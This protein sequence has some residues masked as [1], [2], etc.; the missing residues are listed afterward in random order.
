MRV[1][2]V[3]LTRNSAGDAIGCVESLEASNL[4]D[5]GVVIVDNGSSDDSIAG[6]SAWLAAR[7][8]ATPRC[9]L[10]ETGANLGFPAG[11]NVGIARAAELD[12]EFVWLLNDDT[13]VAED[14]P[15]LLLAAAMER[16]STGVVGCSV[17]D[18]HWP[19]AAQY[20]GGGRFSPLTTRQCY[21]G[22][23]RPLASVGEV[24]E[25]IEYVGGAS[26]FLRASALAATDGLN[27]DLFLYY[28]ELD[29]MERLKIAG[30][31]LTVEPRAIVFHKGGATIGTEGGIRSEQSVYNGTR[32]C[33]LYL[34]RW[35][36]RYVL[37]AT[38]VRLG[39]GVL[40]LLRAPRLGR[41]ALRGLW[42][43]LTAKQTR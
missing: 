28:D 16:S 10:I 6:L 11:C 14:A 25:E 20:V 41:A 22:K 32:S 35:R 3:V 5:F 15:G 40:L 19:H 30:A 12:P 29:L 43:G 1:A 23:G 38:L 21:V 17:V 42:D 27:E 37:T 4:D 13:V 39:Y 9:E 31:S 26:M 34:R 7:G 18:F 8:T 36:R 24:P 33:I 2:V